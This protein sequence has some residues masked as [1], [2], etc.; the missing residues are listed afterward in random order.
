MYTLKWKEKK[1]TCPTPLF[2]SVNRN[3]RIYNYSNFS[4]WKISTNICDTFW[5][6]L[7]ANCIKNYQLYEL[8]VWQAVK[9][10]ITSQWIRGKE[11]CSLIQDLC[12]VAGLECCLPTKE[13]ILLQGKHWAF[14]ASKSIITLE[15]NVKSSTIFASFPV[16]GNSHFPKKP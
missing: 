14:S 12:W 6:K 7:M 9:Q 3:S 4:S 15:E 8:G 16:S 5:D 1:E 10:I 13:S 11:K 2:N